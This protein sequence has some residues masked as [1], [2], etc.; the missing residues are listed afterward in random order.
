MIDVVSY[1][2]SKQK[3][4]SNWFK[5]AKTISD[6]SV[7]EP[8]IEQNDININMTFCSWT[9]FLQDLYLLIEKQKKLFIDL[10]YNK[11]SECIIGIDKS[12]IISYNIDSYIQTTGLIF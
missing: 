3:E 10:R 8:T 11:A 12:L 4:V 9:I 6:V 5:V 7:N 1:H 2:L